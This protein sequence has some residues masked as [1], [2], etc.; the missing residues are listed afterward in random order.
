MMADFWDEA[1]DRMLAE[2]ERHYE[3]PDVIDC[4]MLSMPAV[5]I[6]SAQVTGAHIILTKQQWEELHNRKL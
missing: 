3:Q 2:M 6:I 1:R 4:R 5:R